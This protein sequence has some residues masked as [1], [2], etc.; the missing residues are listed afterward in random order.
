MTPTPQ[1]EPQARRCIRTAFRRA[2]AATLALPLLACSSLPAS[3]ATGARPAAPPVSLKLLAINDFHGNLKPPSGGIQIRDPLHPDKNLTVDAGGAEY[4][5]TAAREL[6]AAHPNHV[7]VAAGDLVGGSPLLSAMFNDEPSVESLSLMGL[8]LSAVGN[9]EFDQGLAELLRKQHGGCH[10]SKGCSGAQPFKGA[11]YQYLAASTW[12]ESTGKTIFPAYKIRHFEGVPVAFIGLALKGTPD[13]VIPSAV[14]G[15]R[16]DDEAETVNRLVPELRA[17]GVNT[18]VLLI[19]EGGFPEGDYNECPGIS[20]PIVDIVKRLD[21]AVGV[22][23]S[24]HTH[25]A[26]N[27]VIDQRLVTSG[28]KYGTVITDIDLQLDRQSGKL[29]SA[30]ANNTLVRNDRYA[31]DAAQAAL[32]AGYEQLSQVQTGRIVGHISESFSRDEW[33]G[34]SGATTMGQLVADAQLAATADDAQIA[35]T[36]IGGI[37][38]GLPKQG[39]GAITFGEVFTAQPFSNQLVTITLSGSQLL[40]VLEQQWSGQPK[41]RPLQF[42]QGFSYAWDAARPVGQRVVAESVRIRGQVLRPE[43]RYR[44]TI[45]NFLFNGGDGFKAFSAGT[46]PRMGMMDSEALVQLLQSQPLTRPSALDRV[47]RRN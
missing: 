5:A 35:I 8:E 45:N 18:I 33:A 19:H 7:F 43:A 32:I 12:D 30:R 13:I 20:G 46:E 26:Y 31:K 37:R 24:G 9:H 34:P 39:D 29:L 47:V 1:P 23:V 3:D 38:A 44:V 22:V 6:R 27:C 16:F 10:P 15:L 2:L 14:R 40:A 42:S 36:N 11:A 28:D 17:Q 4:L 21:R 41:F 25:R